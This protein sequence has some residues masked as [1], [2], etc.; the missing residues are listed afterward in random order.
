V[1][2]RPAV[3]RASEVDP[4]IEALPTG[5]ELVRIYPTERGALSFNSTDTQG[6]FRPVRDG[7]GGIEPTAY[8]AADDETALAEGLLRGTSALDSG[9]LPRRLYRSEVAGL[10]LARVRVTAPI[11]VARFHGAGLTRLGLLRRDVID[12]EESEY[13]YTARWAQAV[14]GSSR[15]PAGIC[16]TSRQNDSAR[17]YMLWGSRIR[18]GALITVGREIALDRELGLDLVRIAC[19]DTNVDFEA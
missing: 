18:T 17:A 8:L 2:S 10:A 5:S 1:N 19:A 15:R 9:D 11:R 6:R 12:C 13:D 14:W 4:L 7:R 16:W 3:P